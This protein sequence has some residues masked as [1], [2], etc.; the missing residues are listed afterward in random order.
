[1]NQSLDGN[2]EGKKSA[3][4]TRFSITLNNLK[5]RSFAFRSS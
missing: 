4:M 3:R 2:S 1:V 5:A